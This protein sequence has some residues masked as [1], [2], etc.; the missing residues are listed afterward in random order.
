MKTRSKS[1]NWRWGPRDREEH[2]FDAETP[3]YEIIWQA[4]TERGKPLGPPHT[5]QLP[6]QR[7]EMALSH[8]RHN[9]Q[10]LFGAEAIFSLISMTQIPASEARQRLE[11][12][13]EAGVQE[14]QR[15]QRRK[16]LRIIERPDD[17]K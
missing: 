16:S 13:L 1:D 14:R 4:V 11:S 5:N 8:A 10:F 17:A 12:K 15:H 2:L 9:M 3:H 6:G 7:P